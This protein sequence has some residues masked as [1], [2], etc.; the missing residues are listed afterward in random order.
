ME[1]HSTSQNMRRNNK[2]RSHSS[3]NNAQAI[4][5]SHMVFLQNFGQ[6]QEGGNQD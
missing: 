6:K 1:R 4:N 5:Q 2:Q 3:S